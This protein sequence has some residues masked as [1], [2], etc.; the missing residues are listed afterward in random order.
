MNATLKG[1]LP[2][3]KLSLTREDESAGFV[4]NAWPVKIRR[5]IQDVDVLVLCE[6][7]NACAYIFPP[8][9]KVLSKIA[10]AW[11]SLTTC[12]LYMAILAAS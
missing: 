10:D 2:S 7:E 6:E 5:A 8:P 1:Q 4:I 3:E 9:S 11:R 12:S